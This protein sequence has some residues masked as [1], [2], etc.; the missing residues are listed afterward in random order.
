MT[1]IRIAVVATLGATNGC[2]R[3][4]EPLVRC[5]DC[6]VT[7]VCRPEWK[8]AEKGKCHDVECE[9]VCVPPVHLPP[10]LN[11]CRED[12]PPCATVLAVKKLE[13]KELDCRQKCQLEF[14]AVCPCCGREKCGEPEDSG[15]QESKEQVPPD[16]GEKSE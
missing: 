12:C 1:W 13:E 15:E 5:D 14:K 10:W 8:P 6:P 3:L 7:K 2:A 4:N 11:W 16:S 9:H